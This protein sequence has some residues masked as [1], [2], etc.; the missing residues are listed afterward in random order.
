MMK[1]DTSFLGERVN[2]DT[3]PDY[4]KNVIASIDGYGN[5]KTTTRLSDIS[6]TPGQKITIEIN[7]E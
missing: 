2:P 4:P 6:Y 1:K 5:I 3:L 7:I